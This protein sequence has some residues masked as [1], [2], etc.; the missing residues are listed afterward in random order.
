[1]ALDAALRWL[2]AHAFRF[3]VGFRSFLPR[4]PRPSLAI[5]LSIVV[6]VA[7]VAQ[8]ML[9]RSLAPISIAK[10]DTKDDITQCLNIVGTAATAA[11]DI[12]KAIANP[13]YVACMA[14]AASLNPITLGAMAAVTGLW[15]TNT[16]A[17][18]N[19]EECN[20]YLVG[21]LLGLVAQ[22]L[23]ALIGDGS[24]FVADMLKSL[25]GQ[26]GIDL[27]KQVAEYAGVDVDSE[28]ANAKDEAQK[29]AMK[30]VKSLMGD[31]AQALGPLMHALECGCAAAGTAAIIKNAAEGVAGAAGACA[32][33]LLNPGKILAAML[34]DPIGTLGAVGKAV[35]DGVAEVADVCGAAKELYEFGKSL[36]DA[37]CEIPGACAGLEAAYEAL[38]CIF[39]G[40]DDNVASPPSKFTQQPCAIGVWQAT[41]NPFVP[42]CSCPAP[43]GL[44][45]ETGYQYSGLYQKQEQYDGLR[46][47][48]CPPGTG[49]N[50]QGFCS[51]CDPGATSDAGAL[52][53][54][55]KL[56]AGSPTASSDG[57][58][59]I[60]YAC[61]DGSE[62]KADNSGCFTC[63]AGTHFSADRKTCWPD[64][65]SA[66]INDASNNGACT[67]PKSD[68]GKT[69]ILVGPN[70]VTCGVPKECPAW[71]PYNA[72]TQSCKPFCSN[73]LQ[74]YQQP[75]GDV[76]TEASACKWCP[77]G[78][79]AVNNE[80]K[81]AQKIAV[82]TTTASPP[83]CEGNNI[84]VDYQCKPCP[85]GTQRGEGNTCESICSAGSAPKTQ[86]SVP[87]AAVDGA[88]QGGNLNLPAG[89]LQNSGANNI[90]AAGQSKPAGGMK[91]NANSLTDAAK[92]NVAAG[93]AQN[94]ITNI[95]SNDIQARTLADN[96]CTQCQPNE[97][98]ITTTLMGKGYAISE[99]VC[100]ACPQGQVSQP[101]G[102]CHE[103]RQFTLVS[104]S[105]QRPN[106]RGREP[107]K[108]ETRPATSKVDPREPVSGSETRPRQPRTP[109]GAEGKPQ[110]KCPPGQIPQD[111]RCVTPRTAPQLSLPSMGGGSSAPGFGGGT[112]NPSSGGF[113]TT[114]IT[115]RQNTDPNTKPF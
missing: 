21:K 2:S 55:V 82:E 107:A 97:Q 109:T 40:C 115:P 29:E 18:N 11:A 23:E 22:G 86:A 41:T 113:S 92:G 78:Y 103:P 45:A 4:A 47:D 85:Y 70:F 48:K 12:S 7:P 98:A 43:Y 73:P 84:A 61:A 3:A 38:S 36:V 50:S 91:P 1:M 88:G 89:G 37:A 30:K 72:A 96:I 13:T 57:S 52:V 15:A 80:C 114:P 28:I 56:Q 105:P 99:T 24:G 100:V 68:D 34:D 5:A 54:N 106:D 110:L 87:P 69:Q 17:F 49:R 25:I 93:A 10:A 16:S 104:L 19:P 42:Y 33:L 83:K 35:C 75:T 6:C 102:K 64:C 76:V 108:R 66:Q 44:I 111:G 63:P 95:T 71:A 101:G 79:E 90:G 67:C 74:V 58:C 46:C 39:G 32:D 8:N 62:Y 31:L 9:P 81:P 27:I 51:K 14:E 26:D 20:G 59:S 77:D 53:G 60:L 94:G 112:R 65:L